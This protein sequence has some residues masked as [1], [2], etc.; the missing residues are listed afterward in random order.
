M[1][2]HAVPGSLGLL[3]GLC[4]VSVAVAENPPPGRLPDLT[5]SHLA[6]AVEAGAT[7]I[8][9]ICESIELAGPHPVFQAII[10]GDPDALRTALTHGASAVAAGP[11]GLTPA[12]VAVAYARPQCLE[13]LLQHGVNADA[14][15]R[16]GFSLLAMAA[17]KPC[18]DCQTTLLAHGADVN[19]VVPGRD[20]HAP[21]TPL[22]LAAAGTSTSIVTALL[23]AGANVNGPDSTDPPL[24]MASIR[25]NL[26]I[27]DMLLAHGAD[28][29][30]AAP[31]GRR[32]VAA[33]CRAACPTLVAHLIEHG[34]DPHGAA[35]GRTPLMI[36]AWWGSDA[37]L[38]ILLKHDPDFL[39]TDHA[40]FD[41]VGMAAARD[42]PSSL[43]LM[44]DAGAEA[45]R[46]DQKGVTP[47]MR[48]CES[49]CTPCAAALLEHDADPNA[50]SSAGWTPLR[51]A[52]HYGHADIIEK[53]LAAGATTH[54]DWGQ[55]MPALQEA[56]FRGHPTCVRVLVQTGH[57]GKEAK[58]EAM[59]AAKSRLEAVSKGLSLT[60]VMKKR[61]ER[62]IQIIRDE[63]GS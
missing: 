9:S 33:A 57:Y 24:V 53:L 7:A 41:A 4:A 32:S 30:R 58:A 39:A 27:A 8:A 55:G 46:A 44:L 52:A 20:H 13:I 63:E 14:V 23:A 25:C 15:C 22:S 50:R 21:Q 40:G 43:K 38:K 2:H 49:G 18:S 60:P 1:P 3:W 26:E 45:D 56:A 12:C 29:D 11:D 31:D 5:H 10:A 62:C 17:V 6:E 34:A 28:P 48:A 51:L 19:A 36:A 37:C 35:H 47:L 59:Y 42:H 54:P 61:Y 16:D